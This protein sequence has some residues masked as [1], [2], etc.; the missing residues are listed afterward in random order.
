LLN[1]PGKATKVVIGTPIDSAHAYILDKFL[2]NQ[3]QIQQTYHDS[4]LVLT[5]SEKDFA[6]KLKGMLNNAKLRGTVL[7]HDLEKPSFARHW[8]W[9]VT[10]GREAIR[11]YAVSQKE[12]AYLLFMDGDMLFER[13]VIA[14]MLNN[15]GDC[16]ALFNGYALRK[17]GI[18]LAGAGCLLLRRKVFTRI[19]FRCCEFENGEVIFEDNLLEMDLFELRAR[20]RKGVYVATDHFQDAETFKHLEPRRIGKIQAL[21]NCPF[22]RYALI[23]SSLALHCNIPWRLKTLLARLNN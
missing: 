15:I 9:D 5:T 18:G 11:Q 12:V 20:I 16:D 14:V 2:H 3:G 23:R 7:T 8:V 13:D 21:T 4:E 6:L 22:I 10:S 19:R 1:N 17:Y